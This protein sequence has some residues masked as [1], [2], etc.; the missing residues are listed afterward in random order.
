MWYSSTGPFA[1]SE[2][3]GRYRQVNSIKFRPIAGS[4]RQEVCLDLPVWYLLE[5]GHSRISPSRSTGGRRRRSK[6]DILQVMIYTKL[7]IASSS[8]SF[9]VWS[10]KFCL[11]YDLKLHWLH[12]FCFFLC[13]VSWCSPCVCWY[14]SWYHIVYGHMV[15]IFIVQMI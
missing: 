9:C 3:L 5:S 2:Q 4:F 14:Q 11:V 15:F 7:M 1:A 6:L 13:C 8:C 12:S 10:F